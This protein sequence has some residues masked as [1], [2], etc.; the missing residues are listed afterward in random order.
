MQ[1]ACGPLEH[2]GDTALLL[3]QHRLL[4]RL[5]LGIQWSSIA[6]AQCAA[7]WPLSSS[8]HDVK[9]QRMAEDACARQEQPGQIAAAAA[10]PS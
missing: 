5:P 7:Q 4:T 9:Q 6:H 2:V 8:E 1:N 10:P 3:R